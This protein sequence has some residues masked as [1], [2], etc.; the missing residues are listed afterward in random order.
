MGTA[1]LTLTAL[2]AAGLTALAVGLE[3]RFGQPA[4]AIREA[5]EDGGGGW[6]IAVSCRVWHLLGRCTGESAGSPLDKDWSHD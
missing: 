6:R 3:K 1:I 2:D 4:T 5:A